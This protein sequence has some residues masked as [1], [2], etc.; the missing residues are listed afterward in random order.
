MTTTLTTTAT[1]KKSR[2]TTAFK[3]EIQKTLATV[4]ATTAIETV[5]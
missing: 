5:A 3:T 1:T 4:L 2:T